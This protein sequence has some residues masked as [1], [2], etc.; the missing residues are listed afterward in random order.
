MRLADTH[1]HVSDERFDADRAQVMARAREA[2]VALFIDVGADPHGNEICVA[3]ARPDER[4][5]AT[6]GIHPHYVAAATEADWQRLAELARL[7]AVVAVGET[8]LDFYRDLSPRDVQRE[9]FERHLALA[10]AVGKPAIVH[11]RDA[12]DEPLDFLACWQGRVRAVMHC[13]S[14]DERLMRRAVAV[15]CMVSIAGNVTYPSATGI[16]EAAR[17]APADSLLVETDC[18][19]LAPVPMRGKR[20]E[21]RNVAVVAR[22]VADLRETAVEELAD[23]TFRN[24]EGFF[25]LD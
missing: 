2:G 3:G 11:S 25:G 5:F 1:A 21:P 17:L 10:A 7:S 9:A 13:F 4:V 14:G 24:A 12:G 6:V 19:Y 16:R 22:A 20:N 23:I 8:G 15:G 18:P